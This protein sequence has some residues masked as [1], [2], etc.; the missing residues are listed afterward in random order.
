MD[1]LEKPKNVIESPGKS[2][3]FEF[4][5]LWPPCKGDA[6]LFSFHPTMIFVDIEEI[7]SNKTQNYT[8]GHN[9]LQNVIKTRVTKPQTE[10]T[11]TRGIFYACEVASNNLHIDTIIELMP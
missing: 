2:W 9:S 8:Q 7:A 3:N 11:V 5:M 6:S 10:T 4:K 1:V